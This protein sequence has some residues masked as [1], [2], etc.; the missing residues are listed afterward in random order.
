MR[1]LFFWG[2]KTQKR[3]FPFFFL[4]SLF[5]LQ[6][7]KH[8]FFCP[9]LF[10]SSSSSL[11][12]ALVVVEKHARCCTAKKKRVV[13]VAREM[14]TLKASRADNF[15]YPP[16]Y[17]PVSEGTNTNTNK[18]KNGALGKR[19]RE[20]GTLTVRFEAPFPMRCTRCSNA[21]L[22]AKGVRFNARKKKI[23]KYLSTPIY[24]FVML[25]HRCCNGEIEIHTDPK[26]GE[27]VC[28]RGAKRAHE[29]DVYVPDDIDVN[30]MTMEYGGID[31]VMV[32]RG[33]DVNQMSYLEKEEE[34]K[35][36]GKERLSRY[37]EDRLRAEE[38]WSMDYEANKKLRRSNRERRREERGRDEEGRRMGFASG[39]DGGVKL[40]P[41]SREDD[42]KARI[43]MARSR[44]KRG[45]DGVNA[46]E[47]SRRRIKRESIFS[48]KAKPKKKY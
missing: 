26:A 13:V 24:S 48:V 32:E 1:F 8:I 11:S 46:A 3:G 36:E 17:N 40:L 30:G 12:S 34:M 18:N 28:A 39:E 43:A 19:K 15:Y 22:I 23:G 5:F 41:R 44:N 21:P 33:S 27:F 20:D 42:V 6:N 29:R 14:S 7:P 45:H 35:K 9:L 37:A 4:R 16:T 2:K 31:G 38:R 10:W 25:S 47:A